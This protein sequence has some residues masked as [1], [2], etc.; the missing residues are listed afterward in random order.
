M[1]YTG[2]VTRDRKY[3]CIEFPDAPGCSTFAESE[4]ALEHA[5]QGALEGWLEAWLVTDETPPEPKRI[6]VPRAAKTMTVS[7]SSNLAA[8]VSLRWTRRRAG[9]SQAELAKRL[10]V[11]KQAV[12]KLERATSNPSLTTLDKVAHAL[13]VHLEIRLA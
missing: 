13:G 9:L 12:Q 11:S 6:R 4:R 7:V 3:W 10:G 8:A 2:V 5:A 1:Q